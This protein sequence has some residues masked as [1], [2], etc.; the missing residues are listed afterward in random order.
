[1]GDPPSTG[2]EPVWVARYPPGVPHRVEIP[3]RLLTEVVEES[4]RRW[5]DR[6]AL[7]YYGAKWTYRRFWQESER[8]AVALA[9]E[10]VGPGDRVALYLPN[11]PA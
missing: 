10:G 5:G 3:N 6:T 11:C 1:M 2:P 8:L 4:V 9:R 7:V